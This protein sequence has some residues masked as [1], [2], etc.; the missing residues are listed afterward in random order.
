MS[1]ASLSFNALPPIRLPFR[2]FITA[3][4][5]ILLCAGLIA[6]SGPDL[7]IG[8]WQPPML[9]LVHGFTLGFLTM[10]M[11]GALLQLLP[12]V[13][14]IG[15]PRSELLAPLTHGLLCLG[16]L[17]LLWGFLQFH[18]SFILAAMLLIAL[19][20]G[21]YITALIWVLIKHISQGDSL[22]GFRLAISSLLV[23]VLL[24]LALLGRYLGIEWIPPSKHLTNVH[25]LW[26]LVGWAGILIIAVS[27]Q[28]IPMF[29]VAPSF[30]LIVR[31]ALT[32]LIFIGLLLS[33][34]FPSFSLPALSL[35]QG[36]FALVLLGV[37]HR[38]KRK[39]PDTSIRYWQLGASALLLTSVLFFIPEGIWKEYLSID[40]TMLLAALFMYFYLMSII[41]GML[42]KILPF[43]SYTHLQQRC[44]IDFTAM[45]YIPNMHEFFDKKHGQWLFYS[46][47]IGGLTLIW[48]LFQPSYYFIFAVALVLESTGLLVIMLKTMKLY[49][50]VDKKITQA[51]KD[52]IEP[53][54]A[55]FKNR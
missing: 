45:Q 48:V 39:V 22:L 17:I 11:L 36:L 53:P 50:T 6:Y 40:K 1:L 30:P 28:V 51:A 25:A 46:H 3:P 18:S 12:V 8:R 34:A 54:A 2:F 47:V 49:F 52:R 21:I 41:E 19:G 33:I 35:L 20:L 32:P 5:F 23:V 26:G 27:Y 55:S 38:R 43:L 16:T 15:I 10:V 29:H 13:A 4:I 14:G 9:A 42:L 37:I 31:R 24:G 44:L 7:W